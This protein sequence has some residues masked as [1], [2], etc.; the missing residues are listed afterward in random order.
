MKHEIFL[1]LGTTLLRYWYLTGLLK[2]LSL[3]LAESEK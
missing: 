1:Q 3:L 2:R